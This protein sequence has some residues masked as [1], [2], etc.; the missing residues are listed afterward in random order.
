MRTIIILIFIFVS[1]SQLCRAAA[2]DL[3]QADL[4][5]LKRGEIL[6]ETAHEE[7]S[8]GAA[9]VTSLFYTSMTEVWDVVGYCE[10]EFVYVRGLESCEV[11]ET[12]PNYLKKHHRVNN[13]W[14]TPTIEFTFEA[15][16]NS[17][18]FGEFRLVEGNLKIMKGQ[19]SFKN[20]V[21]GEGIIVTH[22][23]RVR[24]WF[25]APRWLVRRV[26]KKDLPDMLACVRALAG[27]SGD[28]YRL[29]NDLT[30]CPGK[31]PTNSQTN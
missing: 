7:K 23:I 1:S 15:I 18:D 4:A 9:R 16:R 28:E 26:L 24:S 5:R 3:D 31:K 30:R 29:A 10:Y 8:G 17:P 2:D 14:Y 25:P 21:G 20:L 11:L 13:N 19:W 27:A 22:E 6:V 12:G